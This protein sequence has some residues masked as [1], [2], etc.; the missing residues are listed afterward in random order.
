MDGSCFPVFVP[1]GVLGNI[2]SFL[3]GMFVWY[4]YCRPRGNVMF[5]LACAILVTAGMM[6]LLV[7]SHIL[8][9]DVL[10]RGCGP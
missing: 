6:L 4:A 3:V 10:L 7:W 9:A 1:L 5:S 8:S 2:L